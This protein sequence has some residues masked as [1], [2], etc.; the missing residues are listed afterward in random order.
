MHNC[1]VLYQEPVEAGNVHGLYTCEHMC[2]M[3]ASSGETIW[4]AGGGGGEEGR[5][6]FWL[7]VQHTPVFKGINLLRSVIKWL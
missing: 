2:V 7:M 5:V 4:F 1:T 3:L 6:T